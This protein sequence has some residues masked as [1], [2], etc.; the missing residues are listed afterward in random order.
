MRIL[1][2][3][4]SGFLGTHLTDHLRAAG[5]D[6]TRLVRRPAHA[7]DEASWDPASGRLDP[8][9]VAGADVVINLGGVGVGDK[10]WTERH[11][12]AIRSSRVETTG[13]VARTIAHLPATDRPAVL[14]QASGV[15]W[16]G[17]T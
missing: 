16:S 14:L 10:R 3:G 1:M 7:A 4:A 15:G 2:A 5:H 8:P 11:K 6:I 13:T 17:A 12:N 9:V